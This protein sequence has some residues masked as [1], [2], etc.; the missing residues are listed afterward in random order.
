MEKRIVYQKPD[1]GVAII[2]P[3]PGVELSSLMYL[4][5]SGPYAIVDADEI[6]VD[7][8]Q[9]NAWTYDFSASPVKE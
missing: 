8:S 4:V 9:R 7:R 3:A 1:G 5:P 6:P 2:I